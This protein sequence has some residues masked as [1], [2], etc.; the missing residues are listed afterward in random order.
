MEFGFP[1]QE[2]YL[3]IAFGRNALRQRQFS[4][5]LTYDANEPSETKEYEQRAGKGI[6]DI[7]YK[8]PSKKDAVKSIQD[9]KK[10]GVR[11]LIYP[12]GVEAL[13]KHLNSVR[14]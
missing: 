14:A 2:N 4:A 12:G 9:L 13:I 3:A 5:L 10:I 1:M 7:L 8:G 6:I 11:S